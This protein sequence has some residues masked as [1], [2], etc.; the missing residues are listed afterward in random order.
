MFLHL[1]A[2]LSLP[3]RLHRGGLSA[4]VLILR[5]FRCVVGS[6]KSHASRRIVEQTSLDSRQNS[7]T[8]TYNGWVLRRRQAC[9]VRQTPDLSSSSIFPQ[10]HCGPWPET[11]NSKCSPGAAIGPAPW[12]RIGIASRA[13]IRGRRLRRSSDRSSIEAF[14]A[15]KLSI[16]TVVR[17]GVWGGLF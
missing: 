16:V 2:R 1:I 8:V 13:L 7:V 15:L 14:A 12:T 9:R 5:R 6:V 17:T 11:C 3:A 4:I 10:A